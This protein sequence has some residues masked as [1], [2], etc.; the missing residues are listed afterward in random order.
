MFPNGARGTRREPLA[1]G[2]A[3][4]VATAVLGCSAAALIRLASYRPPCL[5]R[6]NLSTRRPLATSSFPYRRMHAEQ[7]DVSP[8]PGVRARL[9]AAQQD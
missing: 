9:V 8:V 4:R 2:N 6:R 3:A 1:H 5:A 7:P